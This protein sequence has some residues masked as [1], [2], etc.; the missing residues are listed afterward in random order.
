MFHSINERDSDSPVPLFGL[1]WN[2]TRDSVSLYN[3][4]SR[5]W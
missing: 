5:L 2:D 4:Y 1:R 3:V